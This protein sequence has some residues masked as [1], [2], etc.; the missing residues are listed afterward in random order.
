MLKKIKLYFIN[1]L[2]NILLKR[3]IILSRSGFSS[4]SI[5]KL[6]PFVVFMDSRGNSF[7]LL[8][9]YRDLIK[10][11]WQNMFKIKLNLPKDKKSIIE[12][13]LKKID[14]TKKY[15]SIYNFYFDDVNILEVGCAGGADAYA[16]ATLGI[17]HIDAIDIPDYGVRQNVNMDKKNSL[18]IR[19][20][21]KFLQRFRKFIAEL[22]LD[23][24]YSDIE[25]K[26]MF[27]DKGIVN[28]DEKEIYDLILSWETL[29]HIDNPKVALKNMFRALKPGG[30]C[31]H[32]YNPFFSI[33]GGHSLCTLDFPYGHVRLLPAD[34]ESYIR[35]YR[36]KELKVALNFYHESLNRMTI[37]EL[38]QYSKEVGF[39]VLDMH[40]FKRID[41]LKIIDKS[42]FDQCQKNYPSVTL[43]D[44]LSRTVWILL[45][46]PIHTK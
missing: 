27:F 12:N 26:V 18:H 14:L 33:D 31:F 17:R 7:S 1:C 24:G 19:K 5:E 43:N 28:F 35:T 9:G 30:I 11:G 23:I 6:E 32:E 34:F 8:K 16:L 46:K 44:L 21:S 4:E 2:K 25:K 20:Q 3:G 39:E 45:K 37:A 42:V 40:C 29:E 41:A 38:M 36:P 22:Y 15:L 13:A 10:P